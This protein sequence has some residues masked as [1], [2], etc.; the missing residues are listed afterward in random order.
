MPLKLDND[1][2][3]TP[4]F[5]T[6]EPAAFVVFNGYGTLSG[7]TPARIMSHMAGWTYRKVKFECLL[8]NLDYDDKQMYVN[9]ASG[10][11]V[12]PEEIA[13][14]YTDGSLNLVVDQHADLYV[15]EK[16]EKEKELV[17]A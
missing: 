5:E 17:N 11:L 1:G 2:A 16:H 8:G 7:Y 3:L 6:Q 13:E 4:T 9:N 14:R 10:Y 12:A 15:T